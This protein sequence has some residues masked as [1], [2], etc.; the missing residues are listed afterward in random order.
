MVKIKIK[1]YIIPKKEL[2]DLNGIVYS[3]S[4]EGKEVVRI[5]YKKNEIEV[6]E[7]YLLNEVILFSCTG[8]TACGEE[9]Y[10]GTILQDDDGMMIVIREDDSYYCSQFDMR[11]LPESGLECSYGLDEGCYGTKVAGHAFDN[12]FLNGE[13]FGPLQEAYIDQINTTGKV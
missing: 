6:A 3:L 1:A 2:V 10:S 8:Y 11:D 12:T 13:D 9:I 7:V 4:R 5:W